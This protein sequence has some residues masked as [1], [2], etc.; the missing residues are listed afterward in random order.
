MHPAVDRAARPARV[1]SLA[2]GAGRQDDRGVRAGVQVGLAVLGDEHGTKEAH[3]PGLLDHLH[4]G[5]LEG[6][7]L[8]RRAGRVDDVVELLLAVVGD[9]GE[10]GL[11][12]GFQRVL[13]G[14]V[15][16][17]TGEARFRG[18]IGLQE[19]GNG[20]VDAGL[21]RGGD[22]NV[23]AEFETGFGDAKPDS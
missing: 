17:V 14:E 1:R 15:G 21:L 13:V 6:R 18:W 11:D 10:E 4:S 12:V 23:R 16:C 22:D 5:F 3:H 19:A 20:V 7:V 9:L 2:G 8:E